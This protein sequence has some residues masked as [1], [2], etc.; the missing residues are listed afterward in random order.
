MCMGGRGKCMCKSMCLTQHV[1]GQ[2]A[3]RVRPRNRVGLQAHEHAHEVGAQ[4][5]VRREAQ[6]QRQLAL[7]RGVQQAGWVRIRE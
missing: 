3:A 4:E 1:Y 5:R 7:G 6:V 2:A